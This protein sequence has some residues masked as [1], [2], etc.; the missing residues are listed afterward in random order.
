MNRS[1]FLSNFAFKK[2]GQKSRTCDFWI[3][4]LKFLK[5]YFFFIRGLLNFVEFLPKN[6]RKKI[7][8]IYFR[9]R[10]MLPQNEIFAFCEAKMHAI[11]WKIREIFGFW[12]E[13]RLYTC[14]KWRV[15]LNSRRSWCLMMLRKSRFFSRFSFKETKGNL[16]WS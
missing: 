16:F 10:K 14:L 6:A 9:G 1:H 13:Y 8:K 5:I 11:F 4:R 12:T 15:K 7:K 3:F 2:W